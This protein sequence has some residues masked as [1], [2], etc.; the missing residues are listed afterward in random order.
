MGWA[1]LCY[2]FLLRL[3]LLDAT[4]HEGFGI[5]AEPTACISVGVITQRLPAAAYH[6]TAVADC[7]QARQLLLRNG[8]RAHLEGR[9]HR[10]HQHLGGLEI[11]HP[12]IIEGASHCL[13]QRRIQGL[14]QIAGQLSQ[15]LGSMKTQLADDTLTLNIIRQPFHNPLLTFVSL[16]CLLRTLRVAEMESPR[17][18]TSQIGGLFDT[19][20]QLKKKKPYHFQVA[21]T[22]SRWA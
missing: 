12:A 2:S 22:C 6:L 20:F 13:L 17:F 10:R 11:L 1:S 19:N 21:N 15:C 4:G 16:S 8:L 9:H 3:C 18:D 7:L 14:L 5:G